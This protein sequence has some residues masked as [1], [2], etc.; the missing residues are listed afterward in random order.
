[1]LFGN[2]GNGFGSKIDTISAQKEKR[3]RVFF[4]LPE[5]ELSKE[6]EAVH[7]LHSFRVSTFGLPLT[8]LGIKAVAIIE[9]DKVLP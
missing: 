4:P 1:M 6:Q 9:T 8:I 3:A 2:G 7:S 5:W